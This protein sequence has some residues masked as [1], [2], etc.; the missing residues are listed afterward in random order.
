MDRKRDWAKEIEEEA[1][2]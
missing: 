1:L 2:G